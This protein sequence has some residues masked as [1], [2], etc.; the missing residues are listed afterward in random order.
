MWQK[1]EGE[2]KGSAAGAGGRPGRVVGVGVGW[3]VDGVVSVVT[4]LV[5]MARRLR[6]ARSC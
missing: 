4:L 5:S 6:R 1:G 2:G 3:V